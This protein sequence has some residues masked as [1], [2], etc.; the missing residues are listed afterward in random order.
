MIKPARSRGEAETSALPFKVY[1]DVMQR[2]E[3][4]SEKLH[5]FIQTLTYWCLQ[6]ACKR[7]VDMGITPLED[8]HMWKSQDKAVQLQF[9]SD[10]GVPAN[11]AEYIVDWLDRNVAKLTA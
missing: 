6:Q 3:P 7:C 2:L 5:G 8:L 9:F 4:H 1:I 10:L 11:D